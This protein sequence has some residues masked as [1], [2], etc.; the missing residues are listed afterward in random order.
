[1]RVVVRVDLDRRMIDL[2]LLDILQAWE[3]LA[4]EKPPERSMS[5]PDVWTHPEHAAGHPRARVR[6]TR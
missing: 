2:P 5:R 4:A 1:M 6:Q 3:Q